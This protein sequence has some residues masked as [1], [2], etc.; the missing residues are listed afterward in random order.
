MDDGLPH[1]T[2][3][4]TLTEIARDLERVSGVLE[5]GGAMLVLSDDQERELGVLSR[6]E[7]LLGEARLAANRRQQHPADRRAAGDGRPRRAPVA[8]P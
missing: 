8:L 1:P 3:A 7:P 2:D 5:Q 6:Q 4:L